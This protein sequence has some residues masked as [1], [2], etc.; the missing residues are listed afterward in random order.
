M[1]VS[2]PLRVCVVCW[3]TVVWLACWEVGN[4]SVPGD[5]YWGMTSYSG[6]EFH[7]TTISLLEFAHH[8]CNPNLDGKG[9]LDG[10]RDSTSEPAT[11]STAELHALHTRLPQFVWVNDAG[12]YVRYLAYPHS[13][14]PLLV[15]CPA[16]A[17]SILAKT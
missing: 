5:I 10:A 6:V 4:K 15:C 16:A 14:P 17:D 11:C 9:Q 3:R 13:G 8:S 2:V 1:C 12:V 7:F